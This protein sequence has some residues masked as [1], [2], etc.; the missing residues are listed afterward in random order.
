MPE[1]T[2]VFSETRSRCVHICI[3][4]LMLRVRIIALFLFFSLPMSPSEVT[5]HASSLNLKLQGFQRPRLH[6]LQRCISLT[7]DLSLASSVDELSVQ[8]ESISPAYIPA[9]CNRLSYILSVRSNVSPPLRP[10]EDTEMTGSKQRVY[11]RLQTQLYPDMQ[12]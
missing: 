3:R 10:G 4:R 5:A 6:S 9:H 11:T 2:H 1:Q 7:S 8:S 12:F